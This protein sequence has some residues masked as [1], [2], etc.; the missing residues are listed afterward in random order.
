MGITD[1]FFPKKK[2]KTD[3]INE[4][5]VKVKQ[6]LSEGLKKIGL[7]KMEIKEVLN[8]VDAT[9]TEIQDLKNSLLG[10]NINNPDAMAVL[11]KTKVEIRTLQ[12]QMALDIKKKVQEIQKRKSDYR[13]GN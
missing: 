1:W 3:K 4:D 2:T 13:K 10:K 6:N 7:T 8:I 5:R 12:E 11:E 9:E